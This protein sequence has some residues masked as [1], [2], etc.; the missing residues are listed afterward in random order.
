MN[1]LVIHQNFKVHEQYLAAKNSMLFKPQEFDAFSKQEISGFNQYVNAL[2]KLHGHRPEWWATSI[3][4]RNIFF[5]PFFQTWCFVRYAIKKIAEEKVDE[6]VCENQL[7]KDALSANLEVGKVK[8]TVADT[9]TWRQKV[10]YFFLF[11]FI[12][13]MVLFIFRSVRHTSYA[14]Q[15]RQGV[16]PATNPICLVDTFVSEKSFSNHDYND[17]FFG[18]F[19][20]ST[21]EKNWHYLPYLN[22]IQDL[23]K[24]YEEM[25]L[26]KTPFVI[27]EDFLKPA[28]Y[29]W[30]IRASIK[31]MFLKFP[32]DIFSP[33][34]RAEIR[35]LFSRDNMTFLLRYRLAQRLAEKGFKVSGLLDW[36]EAQPLDNVQNLGFK[37]FFNDLKISSYVGAFFSPF[38]AIGY[39]AISGEV[40]QNVS[41]SKIFFYGAGIVANF[42]NIPG[43]SY[44]CAPAFRIHKKDIVPQANENNCFIVLPN[45]LPQAEE[46]IDFISQSNIHQKNLFISLHPATNKEHLKSY[47]TAKLGD[48]FKYQYVER[49]SDVVSSAEIIIST[50]TSAFVDAFMTKIPCLVV[51]SRSK[52]TLNFIPEKFENILFKIV[53]DPRILQAT[54]AESLKTAQEKS[55]YFDIFFKEFVQPQTAADITLFGN[56][57]F[58]S[59]DK[60]VV[61]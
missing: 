37:T 34:L 22:R 9:Q 59:C 18:N 41:A 53:Y 44:E 43:V 10:K 12:Y 20:R 47:I 25:R 3:S 26:C 40:E 54:I 30:A 58:S 36:Y 60:N 24:C 50:G 48:K 38:Q 16:M 15:G 2:C 23:R 28:D 51:G 13:S 42:T 11:R 39:Q 5:S 33:I 61:A 14:S 17:Q 49:F 27:M 31:V 52:H 55:N 45:M 19:I 21:P 6:I 8:I 57:L 4:S 29:L 56:N 46:I 1:I 35:S 32:T 7:I